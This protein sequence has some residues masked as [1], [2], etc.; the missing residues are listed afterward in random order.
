VWGREEKN[1]VISPPR[2]ASAKRTHEAHDEQLKDLRAAVRAQTQQTLHQD[3][4]RHKSGK[5]LQRSSRPIIIARCPSQ[6]LCKGSLSKSSNNR[7]CD[8]IR[9]STSQCQCNEID[10]CCVHTI[11]T[12]TDPVVSKTC[13][14]NCL[15]WTARLPFQGMG[16][17]E[18]QKQTPVHIARSCHYLACQSTT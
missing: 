13:C 18:E 16:Q 12:Y 10:N 2:L 7:R 15:H 5:Q 1:V 11:G 14:N 3:L 6:V 17:P 9:E 4:R 8:D